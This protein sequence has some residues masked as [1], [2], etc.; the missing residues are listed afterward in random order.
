MDYVIP[1]NMSD[2]VLVFPLC[3]K[4]CISCFNRVYHHFDIIYLVMH[5]NANLVVNVKFV[6]LCIILLAL[7]EMRNLWVPGYVIYLVRRQTIA[8]FNV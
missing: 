4:F 6:K 8:I 5:A 7:F 1:E 3:T 2:I